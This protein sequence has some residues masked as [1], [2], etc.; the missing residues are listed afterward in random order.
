ME[1]DVFEQQKYHLNEF[2]FDARFRDAYFKFLD[3]ENG[4][5]GVINKY[6]DLV[7]AEKWKGVLS[8]G[9]SS[10]GR[11]PDFHPRSAQEY[12]ELEA[13]SEEIDAEMRSD[14]E[15]ENSDLGEAVSS[16][17][18]SVRKESNEQQEN[19][20]PGVWLNG[21]WYPT[22]PT[23]IPLPAPQVPLPAAPAPQTDPY[24]Y[25]K[26]YRDLALKACESP[27][28]ISQGDFDALGP[29]PMIN[30]I[31]GA[32]DFAATL[33]GCARFVFDRMMEAN[34]PGGRLNGAMITRWVA[35]S[36]PR[37]PVSPPVIRPPREPVEPKDPCFQDPGS[38]RGCTN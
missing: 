12:D 2:G 14:A 15:A 10:E 26:A 29:F 38:P 27:A 18:D 37:R 21:Q 36:Q 33:S 6:H 20:Q 24:L 4:Q 3:G 8:L 31:P 32:G 17:I 19:Q 25:A 34:R 9:F 30:G 13:H 7:R 28:S 22:N 5:G 35:D 1:L 11:L 16:A 23:K